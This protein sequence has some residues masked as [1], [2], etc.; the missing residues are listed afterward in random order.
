MI[1]SVKFELMKMCY[2]QLFQN[3]GI[4][5]VLAILTK[6]ASAS[7]ETILNEIMI[8]PSWWLWATGMGLV[9]NPA[10]F[11]V[12][13]GSNNCSPWP[14][15]LWVGEPRE[16]GRPHKTCHIRLD[17]H[18]RWF[19]TSSEAASSAPHK[20][21]KEHHFRAA[22]GQDWSCSHLE[23]TKYLPVKNQSKKVRDNIVFREHA[24]NVT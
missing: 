12:S 14:L 18:T 7:S 11:M 5:L 22:V 24:P 3:H 19:S 15:L 4:L 6:T 20:L 21:F 1:R 9:E 13:C 10:N 8:H 2:I 17:Q 16:A 23:F